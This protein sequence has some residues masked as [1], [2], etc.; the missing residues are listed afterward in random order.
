MVEFRRGF[1]SVEVGLGFLCWI[2]K[3]ESEPKT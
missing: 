1:K 3:I 2:L